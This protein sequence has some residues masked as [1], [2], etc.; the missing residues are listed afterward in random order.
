MNTKS[1]GIALAVV[2]LLTAIGLTL[3]VIQ[4]YQVD[5]R[6]VGLGERVGAVERNRLPG[7]ETEID[8]LRENVGRLMAIDPTTPLAQRFTDVDNEIRLFR[9]QVGNLRTGMFS[10]EAQPSRESVDEDLDVLFSLEDSSGK[11]LINQV[12]NTP[13]GDSLPVVLYKDGAV[14]DSF[15]IGPY[16]VPGDHVVAWYSTEIDEMYVEW[17]VPVAP[18][19]VLPAFYWNRATG[20]AIAILR[21]GGEYPFAGIVK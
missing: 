20:L 16:V 8:D 11:L 19:R 5:Q 13:V 17:G 18:Y 6:V 3:L 4:I 14:V 2:S 1:W 10:A 15:D 12:L 21:V 7:L 9:S